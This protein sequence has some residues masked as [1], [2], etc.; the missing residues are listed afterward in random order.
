MKH[1][2]HIALLCLCALS[3][4]HVKADTP[5]KDIERV[6]VV[7][8]THLDVGFTDL[9]SKVTERYLN[10][11]IPAALTLS[12]KLH[13]A[14]DKERYV[15]TTGS[16]LISKYL[17]TASAQDR[18]RMEAAIRRGDFVWNAVPYTVESETANKALFATLL[19]PSQELDKQ[20]G[21][22]TIAA[23]MT[24]VPG[25]TR[26]II[27]LL[28]KAGVQLLHIGVN[29]ACP[30]PSVPKICRWRDTDGSEIILFY[31]SDYGAEDVLPD[32]KSVVSIQFTGDNHGPHSYERVKQIYAD[33][34][35]RYPNAHITGASF[36]EIAQ[37]LMAHKDKLPVVE[38]EIGDTWIYGYGSS[39]MRMAQF[40]VLSNLYAQWVEEDKI[41]MH[42]R[43]AINFAMEL[44]LIAEHTQGLDVKN[45]LQAWD[46]YDTDAFNSARKSPAFRHI[47]ES[48][49]EIDN[50]LLSAINYLPPKLQNEARGAL[51]KSKQVVVPAFTGNAESGNN[52]PWEMKLLKNSSLSIDGLSYHMFDQ[53]DYNRF[54]DTYMRAQYDWAFADLGKPG[55]DKTKALSFKTKALVVKKETRKERKGMRTCVELAFNLP[56]GADTRYTPQKIYA[57]IFQYKKGNK[58]DITITLINK[59]A[60]R[61]PEAYFLSFSADH[62]QSLVAEKTGRE[63][64]LLNVVEKGNRHEHGI[65]RYAD[66]VTP[67]ATFRI[68]SPTAFLVQTGKAQGL[69]YCTEVPNASGGL[70][71]NLSNNLWGTNFSMWNEGSMT[72]HFTIE[73]IKR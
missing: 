7:F 39:P 52:N 40:R 50:Y 45:H 13:N 48:W 43:E 62:I 33:L 42:S 56:K 24:D 6:Y 35:K 70:H 53:N 38:A 17:N 58:A 47:E 68:Y 10:E 55:L 36:N 3:S 44:G 12:E 23:K 51:E 34:A 1:L 72:Y 8:K 49:K 29:P 64:D 65:D 16:W 28:K 69:G 19:L 15:W 14:G 21:R 32:G 57:E 59:P 4:T 63:V 46:K 30:I 31:Q 5:N 25:H 11:F 26:S 2:L 9:S 71:F 66:I 73:R 27:P 20:F 60:V 41:D 18:K 37:A 54:F 67:E 22:H 61:L